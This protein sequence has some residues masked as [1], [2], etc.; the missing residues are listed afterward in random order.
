MHPLVRDLY[1]R[2]LHVGKDYPQGLSFVREKAKQGIFMNASLTSDADILHAVNQGRWW[3][4]EMVGVIQFKKYR[5]MRQRYGGADGGVS[6]EALER[7]VND[8]L[9]SHSAATSV[10]R[11]KKERLL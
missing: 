3:A 8:M 1:R 5:A 6:P 10:G 2:L 11:H 7:A 4:K 9:S